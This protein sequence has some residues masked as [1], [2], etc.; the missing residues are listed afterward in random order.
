MRKKPRYGQYPT[1]FL[2]AIYSRALSLPEMRIL[3]VL[4]SESYG[5]RS[6]ETCPLTRAQ[7][8]AR[9]QAPVTHT[10]QSIKRLLAQKVIF[11]NRA[12]RYGSDIYRINLE[13][14]E[15]GIPVSPGVESE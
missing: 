6:D 10:S 11:A 12:D 8:A 4:A 3:M 9:L 14:S 13:I 2:E 1:V 15:W 5:W 7:I